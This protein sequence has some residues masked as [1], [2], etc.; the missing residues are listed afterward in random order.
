[1]SRAL[2]T[3]TAMTIAGLSAS[4]CSTTAVQPAT[5]PTSGRP[6][7]QS[8]ADVPAGL[9]RALQM[10]LVTTASWDTTGGRLQRYERG[11]S[12]ETWRAVGAIVPVVVGRAGLGWDD[13]LAAPPGQPVKREG[14]GRA[15]AGVFPL[16]T[17]FGFAPAGEA[18][19]V[20][21][22]YLSLSP[23]TD[24]VDDVGSVHYNTVVERGAVPRVDW[25][26]AE[27]MR[28]IGQ[29]QLGVIVGYNASPPRAGRGS[30]IFLHIWGGPGTSTAGCTA[31]AEHDLRDLVL[32]LDRS[33]QPVLVQLPVAEHARLRERWLIP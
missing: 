12:D 6:V 24:C 15:P 27:H 31:M 11:S 33:R 2:L 7:A 10:V 9:G 18:G 8:A 29:Y 22:P 3:A 21:A 17:V 28:Q 25:T 30:C 13:A 1:M 19:W 5:I 14:D 20:R 26:S 16:D 32:W 23:G 4:G